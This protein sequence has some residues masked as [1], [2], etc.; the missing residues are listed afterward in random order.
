MAAFK[1]W[2]HRCKRIEK[3]TRRIGRRER[4]STTRSAERESWEADYPWT[5]PSPL[6][7][8][9][10]GLR[11]PAH[12]NAYR[13][14]RSHPTCTLFHPAF[15]AF[16]SLF[17][18]ARSH[19]VGGRPVVYANSSRWR[20]HRIT[21]RGTRVWSI[22]WRHVWFRLGLSFRWLHMVLTS[23]EFCNYFFI[24]WKCIYNM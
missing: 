8:K 23:F 19:V 11:A 9:K 16:P 2:T 17:S 7:A 21:L 1:L 24:S 3:G 12:P 5:S 10:G 22:T 13:H 4:S 6:S 20:Q 14:R 15:H 18:S